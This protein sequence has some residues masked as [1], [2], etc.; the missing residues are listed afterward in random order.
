[1]TQNS[2]HSTEV[3]NNFLGMNF[4]TNKLLMYSSSLTYGCW[5][6]PTWVYFGMYKSYHMQFL[7]INVNYILVILFNVTN[8]IYCLSFPIKP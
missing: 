8:R 5:M 2:K 4:A 3:K 1:M 6:S 7:K